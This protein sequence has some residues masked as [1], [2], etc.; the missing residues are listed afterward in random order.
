MGSIQTN[1]SYLS[2][3]PKHNTMTEVKYQPDGY[4]TVSTYLVLD[5]IQSELD[6]VTKAFGAK[7]IERIEMPDGTLVHAEVRI[8]DTVVM[9]GPTKDEFG[10]CSC[11]MYIYVEDTDST[12]QN[13]LAAGAKS[14]MEPADQFYGD[15]NAGVKSPGG[16]LY[17]VATHFEDVSKEDLT[18]RSEKMAAQHN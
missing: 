4:T 14:M 8:G 6:F 10:A 18:K 3:T 11:M 13:C 17:W 15:R 16:N 7:E 5:D 12:Y 9:M 1:I 2:I